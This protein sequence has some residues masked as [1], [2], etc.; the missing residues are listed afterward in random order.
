MDPEIQREYEEHM[1]TMVDLL[2]QQANATSKLIN[3]LQSNSNAA[4]SSATATKND[5]EATRK[6]AE[7][8]GGA[9]KAQEAAAV[10]V[11]KYDQALANFSKGLSSGKDAVVSF[12]NAI[13][14][15]ERN[16]GKYGDALNSAGSAAWDIGKNF[17][18]LGMAVGGLLKGV[19]AVAGEAFKAVD[20]V[21][22]FRNETAKFSGVIP[23]TLSDLSAL[24]REA[25][26][27]GEQIMKMS[28]VMSTFGTNIIGLG[29]SAGEGTIKFMKM[30]AV[31]DEV[32][33]QFGRLG[34]DQ[35]R[36]LEM[37]GMYI[38]MQGV[39]GKALE[40]RTKTEA[41]LQRESLA[42]AKNLI[43]M[44][45]L[46]GQTAEQMQQEREV[47]KA[48]FEEQV[49]IRQE[50]IQIQ[51]LRA[52]G[53]YE[54][55]NAIKKE[56]DNRTQLIQTMTDAYGRELGSQFGRVAR[57]GAYDQFTSGLAALG[58]SAND[59]SSMVKNSGDIQADSLKQVDNVTRL[60]SNMI[61]S[62]GIGFQFMGEEAARGLLASTEAVAKGNNLYGK[63]AEEEVEKIKQAAA[64]KQAEGDSLA[65][66]NEALLSAQ[67]EVQALYNEAMMSLA[68]VTL[69]AFAA[70]VESATA[71]L[72]Q[73]VD[74]FK[75]NFDEI[76]AGIQKWGPVIA[77]VVGSVVA[78]FTSLKIGRGVA[79]IFGGIIGAGRGLINWMRRVTSTPMGG[80]ADGPDVDGPDRRGRGGRG[81]RIGRGLLRVGRGLA[82]GLGSLLGG[83][84][85]DYGSEKAAEAG[86][87]RT[88]AGLSVGSSALTYAGAGA[89][90]GSAVPVL[91]TAAGGIIGG[92]LGTGI[93]LYQNWDR[94]TGADDPEQKVLKEEAKEEAKDNTEQLARNT[95]NVRASTTQTVEDIEQRKTLSKTAQEQMTRQTALFKT[96][97]EAVDAATL[98]ITTLAESIQGLVTQIGSNIT[99]L[100]SNSSSMPG[101][102]ADD[103]ATVEGLMALNAKMESVD[104]KYL[105]PLGDLANTDGI[106]GMYHL[107]NDARETAERNMTDAER[108]QL[109]RLGFSGAVKLDQLITGRGEGARFVSSNAR[110]ADE[111]L[112]RAYFR[113][114]IADMQR[115]LNRPGTYLE[116]RIMSHL[117][118]TGFSNYM[119]AL[120]EDP[121]ASMDSLRRSTSSGGIGAGVDTRQFHGRSR[122][123]FQE[124]TRSEINRHLGGE[125]LYANAELDTPKARRII[126]MAEELRR[127]GYTVSGHPNYDPTVGHANRSRHYRGLALDI[128]KGSGMDEMEK[129]KDE[130]D[131]LDSELT[132][133]GFGVLW[134]EE[135]HYD[136]LHLQLAKGGIVSGPSSGYPATLHG[137]EVVTPLNMDSI[138]MRL[139]KTPAD[140]SEVAGMLN[141][142]MS[143]DALDRMSFAHKEMIDVLTRKLDDMI[144]ALDDGNTTR[145]KILRNSMV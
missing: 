74:W 32:R 17:G 104:G 81:G 42:Y 80:G 138:L 48:E 94:L 4:T 5:I 12:K 2:N 126:A 107:S 55:A 135:D 16:I 101:G 123:E 1:R 59:V 109:N 89:M 98:M 142:D 103:I 34:V 92:L 41:Q 20:S 73:T 95:E 7:V 9:T 39:S 121:N 120:E 97:T 93:G 49:K 23:G 143:R 77:A 18:I 129:H 30:A 127:R 78:V 125:G 45:D 19:G 26:F 84:A 83:L 29:G 79:S 128:N 137:T 75:A 63:S 67:R 65:D 71:T 33:R 36:L 10:A 25:R 145:T 114:V 102:G 6:H 133:A 50:N 87:T 56:Q 51:R 100:M 122:R 13:L 43:I 69:P 124:H 96:F 136:H 24:G 99:S 64:E 61:E 132:R 54:A 28:N 35:D 66:A 112:S 140:S 88:A 131:D 106:G 130:F 119:T 11:Q 144:D 82:G 116:G 22:Q 8:V 139:A 27:S 76:V 38:R 37:Q 90:L 44:S 86:H 14:S 3:S 58:V 60:Q 70:A 85:L 117:G 111:L 57:T 105:T 62:V 108:R 91:G 52:A 134:N 46:T 113:F 40:N 53:E 31:T 118:P 72:V 110:Q 68:E 21:V 141:T 115:R 15:S 47:V